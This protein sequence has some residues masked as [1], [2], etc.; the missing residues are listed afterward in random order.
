MTAKILIYRMWMY[1][2]TFPKLNATSHIWQIWFFDILY[3]ASLLK[4]L[5]GTLNVWRCI[6]FQLEFN[7]T[8]I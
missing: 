7:P 6:L 2:F 8:S 4:E 1:Y 5:T 3:L